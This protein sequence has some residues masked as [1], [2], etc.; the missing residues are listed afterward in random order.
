MDIE[1]YGKMTSEELLAVP[2][3]ERERLS[4]ALEAELLRVCEV[5]AEQGVAAEEIIQIL[6]ESMDIG[7]S[8]S[9][10]ARVNERLGDRL[11]QRLGEEDE[12]D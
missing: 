3:E 6:V 7:T 8:Y 2:E 4:F 1:R 5:A 9:A 12:Q 10:I 11:G